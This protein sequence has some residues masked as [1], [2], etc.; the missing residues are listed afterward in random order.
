ML[1]ELVDG[2]NAFPSQIHALALAVLDLHCP[3][4]TPIDEAIKTRRV[5]FPARSFVSTTE[6]AVGASLHRR[7]AK[8]KASASPLHHAMR[9]GEK[10]S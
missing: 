6:H 8:A 7:K 3:I 5:T 2:L 9:V 10:P 4:V 1:A